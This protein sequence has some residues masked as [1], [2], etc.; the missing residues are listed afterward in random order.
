V[1]IKWIKRTA[2]L[3]IKDI[4]ARREILRNYGRNN[5]S[6]ATGSQ[7]TASALQVLTWDPFCGRGGL[8]FGLFQNHLDQ[9]FVGDAQPRK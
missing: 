6:P 3:R 2:K 8:S 7:T 9:L 5:N 1:A 4:V